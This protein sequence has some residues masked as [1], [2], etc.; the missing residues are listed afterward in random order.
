MR[1]AKE[2]GRL[3]VE[4]TSKSAA[5]SRMLTDNSSALVQRLE[6][7]GYAGATIQV[8]SAS[9][10]SGP[11]AMN[12]QRSGQNGDQSDSQKKGGQQK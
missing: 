6:S 5:V 4:F 1:I 11:R 8:R 3:A 7:C 12:Q 10:A 2:N 9:L